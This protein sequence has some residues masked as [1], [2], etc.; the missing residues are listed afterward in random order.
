MG[1]CRAREPVYTGVS[2][3]SL[4]TLPDW[5]QASPRAAYATKRAA[6]LRSNG[7]PTTVKG[8][9]RS[10]I[11]GPELRAHSDPHIIRLKRG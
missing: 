11:C 4:V 7:P 8:C 9:P 10:H 1:D 5:A 6:R 3:R 2:A